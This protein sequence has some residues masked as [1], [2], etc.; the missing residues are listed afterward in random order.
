M[1]SKFFNFS[2]Y[3]GIY[4]IALPVGLTIILFIATIFIFVLPSVEKDLMDSKRE[5]ISELTSNTCSLLNEYN[6]RVNSGELT[7][8]EAQ[9]RAKKR[10]Q[11]LRY[12]PENKDYFWI[13]DMHPKMIM[14]PYVNELNG[15]D[16]SDYKDPN[17]KLIF[18]ECVKVVK[19]NGEGYVDYMW[20][21]KDDPNVIVSKISYV[22]GFKPWNW[23]VG[24]GIYVEDV[25]NQIAVITKKMTLICFGI[26]LV[27]VTISLY[28]VWQGV[29][30][31]NERRSV[32]EALK[33]SEHKYRILAEEIND[34]PY[35]VS[36]EGII[37]YIGP[38]M[39]RY[40]FS[41]SEMISRYFLEFIYED[42][43]KRIEE[44]FK[45]SLQNNEELL[46][47]F[48]ILAK[49]GNIKWF[50]D[51]G[52]LHLNQLGEVVGISGILREITERKIAEET[53]SIYADLG[54]RLNRATNP[55]EASK[56]IVYTAEHLIGWD[57]CF[58]DL[59]NPYER[60]INSLLI[61]GTV[62]GKKVEVT[63]KSKLKILTKLF[64]E[65]IENGGQLILKQDN[66]FSEFGDDL[67]SF[68][69]N[70]RETSSIMIVPIRKG[71]KTVGILSIQ[72][73]EED[74]YSNDDLRTL[75]SLAD[76]CG[77]S[78]ERIQA[79]DSLRQNEKRYRSLFELSPSGIVILNS[80]G[81]II[82][83][84][85]AFCGFMRYKREELIGK[86]ISELSLESPDKIK[87]K[88]KQII[89]G[90]NLSCEIK[91]IRKDGSE[92]YIE[93]KETRIELPD[94]TTGVLAISND[95]SERKRNEEAIRE[96]ERKLADII[97][98]LPDATL[99]V[100][101]DMKV[102]AWNKSIE[103]ISGV[104]SSE[105][106]GKSNY[107]YS[108]PFYGERRPILID[109]LF[110]AN[111]EIESK[112]PFISKKENVFISEVFAPCIGE[113]GRYFFA[114]AS[115]LYDSQNNIVGG[116]ESLRD[117]TDYKTAQ[118]EKEKLEGHLRQ[119]QKME[120][121]GKLAGGV[122]HDFN[123]L[124]SVI[125]G[126]ADLVAEDLNPDHPSYQMVQEISSASERARSLT[127]QLLVFSRKQVLDMK[128]L[129]INNV[130]SD[131]EK[132]LGRL[133]GENIEFITRLD[134]EV[135]DIKADISQIQ[136]IL[137]NLAINAREAMP[138]VGKLLI[139]T[140]NVYIDE[141]AQLD[142]V[143][144]SYVMLAFSDT[145]SGMDDETQKRIFEPFFTTKDTGTG[146]GLATVYGIVKQH[147]GSIW[148]YSEIDKGT[149]FK[150]YFPKAG[151]EN[152]TVDSGLQKRRNVQ[153]SET[154][155]VVEDDESVC[156][157][158]SRILRK[159]N[160]KILETGS[161]EKAIEIANNYEGAIDLVLLDIVLP[162]M[163]GKELYD[164][165]IKIRSDLKVLF[166]SGYTEDT[167]SIKGIIEK[168]MKLINKPISMQ[169]LTVKIREILDS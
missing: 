63:P 86:D 41:S 39:E 131:M 4:R 127:K 10:I 166:M 151:K 32:L 169:D 155:L 16:I 121:I 154:I 134:P 59:F 51:N 71:N 99:V 112:Y 156:A 103:K 14:H 23:V 123:N 35:Y 102:V 116:I 138:Y 87:D 13:N 77:G 94:G 45:L 56:V 22:K 52:K 28:I 68:A 93:L 90:A 78:F 143:P 162:K 113:S 44:E 62:N 50:E 20:Q 21:W 48:R 74:A 97:N 142:I 165:L 145:G 54:K 136:Q 76:H 120:A 38:Q 11:S 61:I 37:T 83:V 9:S 19:E 42:D 79:E 65:V 147:N 18:V 158:V 141:K 72:S 55:V 73:F 153:G 149:T 24:T 106:L 88:I 27:I 84:N 81:N 119:S 159:Q 129:N 29:K 15:R 91:N 160:Y 25:K 67:V 47:E 80:K 6:E 34:I 95:I 150:I 17:G 5:M 1:L 40:G 30:V 109:L 148:V 107:E 144:G 100:D 115:I 49:C 70:S 92:C 111:E 163:N 82:D 96:S 58:V 110:E 3:A 46:S 161:C 64:Q 146:L 137:M 85:P 168:G 36:P 43:K 139:E 125:L 122:A 69:D 60:S 2:L 157:L 140:A 118:L 12:G 114:A 132:M 26:L 66:N 101:K 117:V 128:V 105:M 167:L 89:D 152:G 75:Q 33:E 130:V 7:L 133:I 124:L 104:P 135:D 98:F 126:Y 108:I 31:D 8:E 57:A 164:K 53:S